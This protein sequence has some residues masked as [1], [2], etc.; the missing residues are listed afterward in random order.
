[1]KVVL[2]TPGRFHTFDLARQLH[3]RGVLGAVF[4]GYPWFKLQREQLPRTQVRTWPWL[5]TPYMAVGA[6]VPDGLRREWEW[7]AHRGLDAHVA[8]SLPAC[9]VLVAM[10]GGGLKSG[11]RA[12]SQ[13]G[14]YVCDRG[15]AHI[16]VQDQLLRQESERWGIPFAGID[17]RVIEQE[18]REYAQA[19]AI[20]V[21]STFSRQSF[22]AQGVPASR[23]RLLPYGVDV[24]RF[25][26]QGE[27]EAHTFDV[28][29][30]GGMTLNKG[31]PYLLQA[32]AAL[33]HPAKRLW[34]AGS[35]D[36]AF[37]LRMKQLVAQQ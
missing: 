21:P 12:Q 4:S 24:G 5:Q 33:V 32:F 17:P 16:R 18:E 36:V 15:S 9:D 7:W 26:P 13:G 23:V 30:A 8:R 11:R 35:P 1:M 25:Q 27:P 6:R 29:Y 28:L 10:S 14:A 3:Q 22:V 20:T 34:M 37:I 2:S 31:L 19:D